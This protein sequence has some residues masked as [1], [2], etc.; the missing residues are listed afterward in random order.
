[1]KEK[2]TQ[3]NTSF[4]ALIWILQKTAQD[5][6]P[7]KLITANTVEANKKLKDMNRC[8]KKN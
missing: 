7:G 8:D 5:D 2:R 3:S 6:C 4:N 1:M